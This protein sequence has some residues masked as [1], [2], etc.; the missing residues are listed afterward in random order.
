MR[1]ENYITILNPCLGAGDF[2]K[3]DI[4]F[5]GEEPGTAGEKG[6]EKECVR[7]QSQIKEINK[8]GKI[9]INANK[10]EKGFTKIPKEGG[11][12]GGIQFYQSRMMCYLN[13]EKKDSNINFFEQKAKN[14]DAFKVIDDYRANSLYKEPNSFRY[15]SCLIDYKPLIRSS[16][17]APLGYDIKESDYKDYKYIFNHPDQKP[18]RGS[19]DLHKIFNDRIDMLK[20]LFKHTPRMRVIVCMG[21]GQWERNK[22]LLKI[23]FENDSLKYENRSNGYL[24]AQHKMKG[25]NIHLF[26]TPFFGMGAL[27]LKNLGKISHDLKNILSGNV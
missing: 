9:Y 6:D 8:S 2:K 12:S 14:N 4:I 20:Y 21:K 23:L 7:V 18:K 10:P 16:G 27:T 24:Y 5:F 11:Y 1:M 19:D 17:Q 26:L 22:A 3:A 25:N 15:K 13:I